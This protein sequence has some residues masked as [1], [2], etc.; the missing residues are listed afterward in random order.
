M[1]VN[2]QKDFYYTDRQTD[3]QTDSHAVAPHA[4]SIVTTYKAKEQQ[5]PSLEADIPLDNFLTAATR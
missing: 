5:E 3:R 2:V 1:H 4:I